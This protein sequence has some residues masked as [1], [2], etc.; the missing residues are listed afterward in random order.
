MTKESLAQGITL[1]KEIL[2]VQKDLNQSRGAIVEM[3]AESDVTT[4]ARG[5]SVT[6]PSGP[7]KLELVKR[8]NALENEL[9]DLETQFNAL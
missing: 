7:F 4:T 3:E 8:K 2:R 5:V 9:S 1:Q 6:L